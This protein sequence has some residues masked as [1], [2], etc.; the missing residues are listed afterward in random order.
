MVIG[1]FNKQKNKPKT[2]KTRIKNQW[3]VPGENLYVNYD[4]DTSQK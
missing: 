2:Q 1:K 3:C 4:D